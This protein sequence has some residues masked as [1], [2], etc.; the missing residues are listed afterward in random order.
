M[1]ELRR[2]VADSLGARLG[3][4]GLVA[5]LL[6][7][8]ATPGI[9]NAVTFARARADVRA[10]QLNPPTLFPSQLPA[11]H[12]AVNVALSRYGDEFKIYFGAPDHRDCHTLPNPNGWCV[13]L[14]RSA[15]ENLADLP[16]DSDIADLQQVRVGNRT[17]WFYEGK[18]NA[19]GWWMEWEQLG[20]TYMTW[21]WVDNARTAL[22]RLT[23]F[24]KSLQPL[25][26]P[27]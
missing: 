6:L 27:R 22:R 24:V 15:G 2:G 21:A 9:A 14:V 5:A 17:V 23:P 19:G 3:L 18:A 16:Y 8:L 1:L 10:W 13:G 20:R 26:I 12:R 25:T 11:G 7:A 4:V